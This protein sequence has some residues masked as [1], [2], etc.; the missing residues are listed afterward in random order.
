MWGVGTFSHRHAC[1]VTTR[2]RWQSVYIP[3]AA[4]VS[5]DQ[6]QRSYIYDSLLSEEAVLAFEYGYATTMPK[7]LVDLGGAVRRFRQRRPGGDRPVR[8][9]R[10]GEV[11]AGCAA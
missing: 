9:L 10:R 6:A 11:G 2:S 4:I 7:G 5:E 3:H 8:L 1:T